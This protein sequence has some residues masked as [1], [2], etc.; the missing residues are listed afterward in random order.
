MSRYAWRAM[1]AALMAW[2]GAV[3]EEPA[4]ITYESLLR[5]L[6]DRDAIARWPEPAY[7]CKQF[8]SYDR[9]SK[10]PDEDWFA[11]ADAG[12]FLREEQNAGRTEWVLMDTEGPGA[13]VRFWSANPDGAGTI[14]I[15]LDGSETPAIETPLTDLLGGTWRVGAPLAAIR[16]RGW[17]LYLPVPYVKSC[18]VTADKDKFYYQIN[19]RTYPAGTP[20]QTFSMDV[21]EKGLPVLR[22]VT[23][24]LQTVGRDLQPRPMNTMHQDGPLAQEKAV[25]LRLPPGPRVVRELTVRLRGADLAKAY[26]GVVLNM[27]FD[28][29][30]T[31]WCPV[32]DFFGSGVGVNVFR[33]WWQ[34][35]E[36]DGSMT[37]YWPMPYEQ[38]ATVTLE[39]L[40]GGPLEYDLAVRTADWKWDD[41]SMHFR[42]TWRHEHPI[43]TKEKK[44]W[45]YVEVTGQ[46]VYAGDMLALLN[47]TTVWWGEGDEKIYVDGEPFPSHFGTG[48]EDY[49]GYAWGDWHF[50]EGPF[51]AQP[52][53]DGPVGLGHTTVFRNRSLDAIPFNKS[54]KMDIEVWHHRSVE[55]AYAATT[56]YYARPAATDNRMVDRKKTALF[57]PEL[58]PLN[59][60]PGGIE[61]EEME[62]VS[63]SP[64]VEY[65]VEAAWHCDDQSSAAQLWFGCKQKGDAVELRCPN[66]LT[67]PQKVIIH[68]SRYPDYGIVQVSIDGKPMGEPIDL[69]NP[70]KEGPSL[71]V[72]G[73]IELGTLEPGPR[74]P[75]IRIEVTGSNP[76]AKEPG[77]YF[78]FDAVV[79]EPVASEPK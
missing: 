24:Q 46:G 60:V 12:Q 19:Y 16:G 45:N 48:T 34:K 43:S 79:F 22:D 64:G 52:R 32:G 39:N 14:R 54:L 71:I 23:I 59:K 65:K 55:V 68:M 26:R 73:P 50:F 53:V 42:S 38:S 27:T 35:V 9:K 56:W 76:E 61:A 51:H 72:T 15:Y 17:N 63:M 37:C 36:A 18:K 25:S 47:P 57:V 74:E 11:N 40:A 44:D 30:E 13:I 20:V 21:F 75:L 62:I 41:R 33:S 31:A 6:V 70:V 2:S 58:K 5:E 4:G 78:G 66:V 49:Y 1:L 7:T 3:A 29:E 67:G 77:T 8:S 69:C 28:G 10:S